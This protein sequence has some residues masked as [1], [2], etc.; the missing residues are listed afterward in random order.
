MDVHYLRDPASGP[1]VPNGAIVGIPGDIP[2]GNV[3]IPRFD[4]PIDGNDGVVI[5][6]VE[7]VLPD[8]NG[9]VIPI[10]GVGFEAGFY[11]WI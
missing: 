1:F 6:G 11:A 10:E 2:V 9:A 3:G 4:V 8:G 7:N 5:L